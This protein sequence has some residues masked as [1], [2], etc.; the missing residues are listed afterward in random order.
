MGPDHA[1]PAMRERLDMAGFAQEFLRRNA[2]YR[3]QY[4]RVM[5]GHHPDRSTP[6]QEAMA[7]K[8]GLCFPVRS[9]RLRRGRAG[10]VDGQ[11]GPRRHHPRCR[12]ARIHRRAAAP[13]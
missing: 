11:P 2:R 1:A 13:A 6:E 5:R 10:A 4:R 9:A 8:W 7:R 12:A 3:A